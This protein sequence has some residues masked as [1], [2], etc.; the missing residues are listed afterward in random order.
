MYTLFM[1]KCLI[2]VVSIFY[3]IR[4]YHTIV[5]LYIISLLGDNQIY[6][7]YDR[8]LLPI[9][10]FSLQYIF[11]SLVW[12][13]FNSYYESRNIICV[14]ILYN[15]YINYT[16]QNSFLLNDIFNILPF[17]LLLFSLVVFNF[18]NNFIRHNM[19]NNVDIVHRVLL[20]KY[21]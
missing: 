14:H 18:F 2:Q 8:L 12:V 19:I 11:I 4:Y 7:K 13:L 15:L 1:Y 5:V 10:G 20:Y 21:R 9:H 3:T 16:E 17:V 6:Q